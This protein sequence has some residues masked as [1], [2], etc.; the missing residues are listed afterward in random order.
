MGDGDRDS[1]GQRDV[2]SSKTKGVSHV[3][4]HAAR[5]AIHIWTNGKNILF[6]THSPSTHQPLLLYTLKIDQFRFYLP[7][8]AMEQQ[9]FT[10]AEAKDHS[11]LAPLCAKGCRDD[12]L[13]GE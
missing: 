12:L 5:V 8:S 2:S 4:D 11:V 1:C 13:Q 9:D 6:G 7:L 10:Q 3:R